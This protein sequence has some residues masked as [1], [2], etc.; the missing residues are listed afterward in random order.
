MIGHDP[1]TGQEVR[2]RGIVMEEMFKGF[3]RVEITV[4]RADGYS[5]II[6]VSAFFRE[7]GDGWKCV[8]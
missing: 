5:V 2:V 1:R 8:E 7:E 4:G 3:M 6:P